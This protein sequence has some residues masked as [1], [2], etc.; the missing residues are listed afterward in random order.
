MDTWTL[1]AGY[2]VVTVTRNGTDV[3]ISQQ[4]Y[5]LPEID[6]SDDRRWFIPITFETKALRS[7]DTPTYMLSNSD[8]ITISDIVD[9]AHWLYVNI[10]RTGYYR[11][12]YDYQSWVILSR[13]YDELPVVTKAQLID[14]S[15]QLARAEILSYDIPLTFLLKLRGKHDDILSWSAADDG[16]SYLKRMLIREPAYEQF[17]AFIKYILKPTYDEVGF[18]DKPED[19]HIYLKHRANVIA[20]ACDFNHDRCV[21]KAQFLF[22]DWM[23]DKLQNK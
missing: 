7:P 1:Q 2:P 18:E 19:S 5:M 4:R 6:H 12:N 9:P 16:I 13:S 11:V 14:D 17:R 22:R 21:N 3:V 20:L 15:L 8:N 23:A 10:K